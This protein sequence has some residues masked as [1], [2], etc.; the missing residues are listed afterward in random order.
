MRGKGRVFQRYAVQLQTFPL[1][2]SL[3]CSSVPHQRDS[4]Q[5]LAMRMRSRTQYPQVLAF[6]QHNAALATNGQ[7][8]EFLQQ[9]DLIGIGH[10]VSTLA[11]MQKT[12]AC[13]R[14]G[15]SRLNQRI[16]PNRETVIKNPS[17]QIRHARGYTKLCATTGKSTPD[18]PGFMVCD[19]SRDENDCR[20]RNC[21]G[22]LHNLAVINDAD[23]AHQ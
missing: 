11:C 1:G 2:C 12:Y 10:G 5:S 19:L 7:L 3:K 8:L 23:A 17:A 4:S 15:R 20:Y 6:A 21:S 22:L 14:P 9:M 18:T 16:R 13:N